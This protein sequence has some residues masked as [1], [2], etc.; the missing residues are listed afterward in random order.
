[1]EI[2]YIKSVARLSNR[3]CV[4]RRDLDLSKELLWISVDQ[5]AAKLPAIKVGG[6]KSFASRPCLNP[7]RP[8]RAEQQIFFSNLQL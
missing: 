7:T 4:N 2:K 8:R 6:K 3:D 1:M 5:R